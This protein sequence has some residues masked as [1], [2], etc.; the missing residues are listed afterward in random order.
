MSNETALLPAATVTILALL[1]YLYAGLNVSAMRDR[2]GIAPP[3][4]TGAA[5]FE[6][7]FRVHQNTLEAMPLFLAPLWIASVYFGPWQW[8]PAVIGLVWIA[9][10]FLYMRGY[11][12]AAE[13]R[14][15][16]LRFQGAAMAV[17]LVLAVAG[18]V[19]AKTS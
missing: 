10:R 4:I 19:I 14:A 17:N 11:L 16:G 3:A 18:I 8:L 13:R 9:G 15:V 5:E 2:Y 1:M 6:R 7:A 12:A